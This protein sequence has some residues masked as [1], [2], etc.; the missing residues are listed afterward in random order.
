MTSPGNERADMFAGTAAEKVGQVTIMSIAHLKLKIS[1]RFRKAKE[2]WHDDPAHHGSS[3]IPPPPPKKCCL[4]RAKNAITRT[5]AQIW[6]GHW[7]T[8]TYLKR[9][10]KRADD[11]FWFCSG[12]VR[13]TR[14][15]VLLYCPKRLRLARLEAWEGKDA[16]GVRVL[17]ANPR[18]EAVCRVLRAV[19][20]REDDGRRDR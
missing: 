1:E 7:R 4:D 8:A 17:L 9:I 3:E 2:A 15:H 10:R 11:K 16:G 18:W 13:M 12:S 19:R 14:S 5:A 20:S 6:T